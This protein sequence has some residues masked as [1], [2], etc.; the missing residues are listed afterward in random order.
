MSRGRERAVGDTPG[1]LLARL[2]RP[3]TPRP[4]RLAVV[5]DPHVAVDER[6]TWKVAHRSRDLLAEALDR[7]RTAG[8]DLAVLVGDLTATA[9]GG[10]SRPSTNCSRAQGCRGSL[11]PATT[12]SPRPS[13][14]T[15]D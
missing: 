13:T 15:R 3:R 2:D 12:T 5:A 8:A 14:T 4:V 6:G 10:V 1:P 11:S 9:A 7:A